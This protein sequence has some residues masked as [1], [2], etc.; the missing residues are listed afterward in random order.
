MVVVFVT[1]VDVIFVDAVTTVAEPF[2]VDSVFCIVVEGIVAPIPPIPDDGG[3][4][5]VTIA[6]DTIGLIVVTTVPIDVIKL[7]DGITVDTFAV[8]TVSTNALPS[9]VVEVIRLIVDGIGVFMAP[10]V[11]AFTVVAT[12]LL[13]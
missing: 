13:T 3:A 2:A 7:V 6:D 11:I 10:V 4:A 1:I 12:T 9:L 8:V 5:A